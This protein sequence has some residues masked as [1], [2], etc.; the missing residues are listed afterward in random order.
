MR[1][2]SLRSAF[3]PEDKGERVYLNVSF[4][5]RG[6]ARALQCTFDKKA[7]MWY[8]YEKRVM[9][10][11][12]AGRGPWI[13]D[14]VQERVDPNGPKHNL[15][16]SGLIVFCREISNASDIIKTFATQW[17]IDHPDFAIFGIFKSEYKATRLKKG[18]CWTETR[19]CICMKMVGDCVHP[20]MG[21]RMKTV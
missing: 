12:E 18:G 2:P 7:K 6:E 9:K 19:S 15:D 4:A 17:N 20:D 11:L 3:W 16:G 13:P 10:L 14:W 1:A 8:T 5:D 21:E